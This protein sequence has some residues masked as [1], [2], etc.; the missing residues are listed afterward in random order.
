MVTGRG[1]NYEK[2]AVSSADALGIT[3]ADALH[4]VSHDPFWLTLT[5]FLLWAVGLIALFHVAR[6]GL[7]F[8]T[9]TANISHITSEVHTSRPQNRIAQKGTF[10]KLYQALF[11]SHPVFAPCCLMLACWL[12]YVVFL[13]PGTTD[14]RDCLDQIC[15]M[16]GIY[17]RSATWQTLVDPNVYLNNNNPVLH[18]LLLNGSFAVGEIIGS[19]NIGFFLFTF[20]QVLLL[21]W[22]L[23]L[24]I[25]L[26]QQF[27]SPVWF[28]VGLL[29]FFCL[30]PL[31]PIWGMCATKDVLFSIVTLFFVILSVYII[32]KPEQYSRPLWLVV[33]FIL[34]L[35]MTMLRNNG[36][37]ALVFSLPFL[38]LN[39]R[40]ELR[41]MGVLA[42]VAIFCF[43]GY[44]NVVLPAAHITGGS[45]REA[46]SLPMQQTTRYIV[47]YPD[48]V[49]LDEREAISTVLDYDIFVDEFSPSLVDNVK[50][51]FNP[52]ASSEDVVNY[53]RAWASMGAK[54]PGTYLS[55]LIGQAYLYFYPLENSSWIWTQLGDVVPEASMDVRVL[56]ERSR[57]YMYERLDKKSILDQYHNAGVNIYQPAVFDDI[58]LNIRLA[59]QS[60]IRTRLSLITNMAF[61]AWGILFLTVVLL[62]NK[63]WQSLIP[64]IPYLTL[65][66]VCIASPEGGNAR[67]TLPFVLAI[68]FLFSFVLAELRTARSATQS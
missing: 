49:S 8:L 66:L 65:I 42:V 7:Y 39:R 61:I 31:Y 25:S 43:Y 63:Q 53:L 51:T 2:L 14:P 68:P 35:L 38:F 55:A 58:R 37:F 59:Y 36:V 22:A 34:A 32:R 10:S 6:K 44:I 29:V 11:I 5:M 46:L 30:N 21:A 54:H 16:H 26:Q 57:I 18:T 23:A 19:Q 45:I 1:A 17:Y 3:R 28:R 20:G 4:M 9:D 13:F 60:Y 24:A 41:K 52:E 15:Q 62:G 50:A 47:N 67:Y 64:L 27:R 33:Y 56:Y 12:P 48:E 40:T